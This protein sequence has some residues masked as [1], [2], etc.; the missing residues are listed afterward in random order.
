LVSYVL[1]VH[2]EEGNLDLLF[3]RLRDATALRPE[4]EHEFL[5]VNDGSRDR[6]LARL[7]ALRDGDDRVRIVDLSR[8]F[9]HQ[10]AVTAGLDMSTGD[11]VVI[12]DTDLQDPPEVTTQLIDRWLEGYDVVYA[13]RSSRRDGPFKRLSARLFYRL[14]RLLADVEIPQDTGDFRLIDGKVVE[15]LARMREHNRFLRGMVSFVGFRQTAVPFDRDRRNAGI[16]GY[17]LRKMFSFASDGIMGF[18]TVPLKLIANLGF[19]VSFLAFVGIVYAL[20]VKIVAPETVI[21]GWT[22]TIIAVLLIGGVQ[23]IVT[24]VL[25]NYIARIYAEVQGRPLY[26][27]DRAYGLRVPAAAGDDAPAGRIAPRGDEP[28][29]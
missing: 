23:M 7:L 19:A 5:F 25:G 22:F 15:A 29:S 6:S 24:G 16:S 28:I 27:I 18:S 1:P 3:Q 13:Q 17:P 26:L 21:D 8:N 20:V 9:G 14:L 12:M 11:A 2:N 4:L 10:A